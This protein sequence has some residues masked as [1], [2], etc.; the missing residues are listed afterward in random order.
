LV[1]WRVDKTIIA[2]VPHGVI[3]IVGND[4][5]DALAEIERWDGNGEENSPYIIEGFDFDLGGT[6]GKC[7]D[8]SDTTVHFIIRNCSFTGATGAGGAGIYLDNVTNCEVSGN[9]LYNNYIGMWINA[10]DATILG[11]DIDVW[12]PVGYGMIFQS[13]KNSL[14]S[15]NLIE[16]GDIGIYLSDLDYC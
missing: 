14:I 5:F 13:T 9:I 8:I 10:E 3:V 4:Q 1:Q 12:S 11:N 2:G 6:N 15:G 16:G 7:I